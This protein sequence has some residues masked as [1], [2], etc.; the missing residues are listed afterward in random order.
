[1]LCMLR[2]FRMIRD[3]KNR[4]VRRI[5]IRPVA[6]YVVGVQILPISWVR[7]I[8]AASAGALDARMANAAPQSAQN[9]LPGGFS[10][11]HAV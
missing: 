4:H 8:D 2:L 1:M 3:A 7:E 6:V 11:P 9:F 5:I 10:A